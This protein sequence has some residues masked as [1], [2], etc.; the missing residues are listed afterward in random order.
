MTGGGLIWVSHQFME[1]PWWMTL[2]F[3]GLGLFVV[4]FV[5][6]ARCVVCPMCR[7]MPSWMAMNG[8]AKGLSTMDSC[9]RCGYTPLPIPGEDLRV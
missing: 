4:G 3:V 8:E 7:A 6:W 9:P 5:W 1:Q 2:D